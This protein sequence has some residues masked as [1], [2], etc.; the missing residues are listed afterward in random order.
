MR[1]SFQV[2]VNGVDITTQVRDRLVRLMVRDQAGQ[3]ADECEIVLDDR[4][5]AMAMPPDGS[6]VSVSLGYEGKGLTHVGDFV[7]DEIE[8]SNTPRTMVVKA[9]TTPPEGSATSSA[10]SGAEG[11]A[12]GN[13]LRYVYRGEGGYDSFNRG[14]AGDSPGSYPGGLQRLTIGEVMALQDA[15]TV[16]AVGAAQFTRGTLPTAMR[17]AG[18]SRG[19]LFSAENQDRMASA[20]LLGS[21]RPK[22]SAYLKGTSADLVG[23]HQE[24]CQEFASVVCPSGVGY[25]DGLNGNAATGTVAEVQAALQQARANLGTLSTAQSTPVAPPGS[26]AISGGQ[27]TLIKERR[28]QSWHDTTLQQIATEIAARN[29]LGLEIRGAV[30]DVK[31]RHEDQTNESDQAFLTRLALRYNAVVKPKGGVILIA[32]ADEGGLA[33]SITLEETSSTSWRARLKDRNRYSAV[34]ARYL[35]R[36]TNTEKVIE[37]R[38]GQSFPTFE[39]PEAYRTED[40]AKIAAEAKLGALVAGTVEISITR[41]GLPT[42]IAEGEITLDGFRPEIDGHPWVIKTVTHELSRNGFTTTIDCGTPSESPSEEWGGGSGSG[43]AFPDGPTAEGSYVQGNTGPTS[44]GPHF[45]IKR[46][47]GSFFSRSALDQYVRVNGQPLSSGTTV[48]GGEFGALRSY[49]SHNGWDFAFTPGAELKLTNGAEWI[50]NTPG[51][52]NGDKAS[53]RTPDGKVYTILHG[54]FKK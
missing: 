38:G 50:G 9:T 51:T 37:H 23:A 16:S 40:E 14:T 30:G 24:L 45:D 7:V 31:I 10:L 11:Q 25:Y 17:D 2:V 36:T 21:K 53:F 20:L 5:R 18:L 46:T 43:S 19:D 6:T 8:I 22:L 27:R 33:K 49:G 44:T 35:D 28:S 32:P 47:D 26:P 29:G 52:P 15:G 3:Q 4:D 42:L 48:S 41:E 13:L 54:K 39:L 1:P 12:A 34:K